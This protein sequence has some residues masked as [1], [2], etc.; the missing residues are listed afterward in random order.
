MFG[1]VFRGRRVLVTGHTGFKG[2]W[3]THWL[4]ALGAD[5]VGLS[6]A[7][8]TNPSLFEILRLADRCVHHE[9]DLRDAD[10]IGPILRHHPVEVVLHLA[11]QSLVRASYR[12]P[13]ATFETNVQGTVNL[14]EALRQ[15]PGWRAIVVV[16]SDKCYENLGD[17]APVGGYRESDALGGHDPYSASKPR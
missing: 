16:T 14:L 3:L 8:N 12:D 2:A 1:D 15:Q 9:H 6:L 4:L 10:G 17:L 7:P 11:A 5:V 13:R